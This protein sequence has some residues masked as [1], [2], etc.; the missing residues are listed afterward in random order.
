MT[1]R[2]LV[3]T[4][5]LDLVRA[6]R[7]FDELL[8]GGE[9]MACGCPRGTQFHPVAC[10]GKP[11]ALKCLACGCTEGVQL[12]S[13]R[14][15]YLKTCDA[16]GCHAMAGLDNKCRSGEPKS[17]CTYFK[18]LPDPNAPFPLCRP[19]AAEH[20]ANWDAQWAEHRTGQM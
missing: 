19:C 4:P 12:E 17:E 6:K 15:A 13:S 16:E 18:R 11:V 9:T 3:P 20:H 8:K 7:R 14:T 1:P 5:P 10:Y 2:F